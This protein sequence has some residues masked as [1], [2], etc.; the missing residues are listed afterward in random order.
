M[1]INIKNKKTYSG[2]GEYIGRGTPLGNP[3]KINKM[4]SRKIAVY[5]YVRYL[6]EIL[7][8]EGQLAYLYDEVVEEFER[9]FSILIKNQK[10][11]L[12]CHCSP[13]LCHGNIVRLV[14]MNKY[15]EGDWLLKDGTIGAEPCLI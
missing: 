14:L 13:E 7:N 11:N 4:Q 9:L 10:L 8:Q 6:E 5:Q 1:Y 3:F 15:H 12:I 2:E